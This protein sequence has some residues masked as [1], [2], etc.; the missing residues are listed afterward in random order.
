MAICQAL[1]TKY[2][3]FIGNQ[4]EKMTNLRQVLANNL[5][6][7]RKKLGISQAK[8]A[9]KADLSTQYLAMIELQHKFPSPEVLERLAF[10]LEIDTPELFSMP[11][12]LEENLKKYKKIILADIEKSLGEP[13]IFAAK[14]AITNMI[15]S[16]LKNIDNNQ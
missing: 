10:A 5:R 4:E 16:H 15:A 13:V 3:C 9:E 6:E 7:N 2:D 8:L 12:S 1:F 11:A 14:I